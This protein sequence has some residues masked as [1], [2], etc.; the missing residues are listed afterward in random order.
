MREIDRVV[1]DAVEQFK[2]D[3]LEYP[4][5]DAREDVVLFGEGGVL[6][7]L[8]LVNLIV[9]VE[10]AIEADLGV[11]VTIADEHALEAT[12]NPFRT[13]EALTGYAARLVSEARGA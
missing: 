7:S 3:H 9:A 8:G 13:I 2:N 11:V 6:D 4:G 5:L 12:E 1:Y 10:E